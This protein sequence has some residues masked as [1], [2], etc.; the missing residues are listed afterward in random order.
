MVT[1][2]ARNEGEW[3]GL[4]ITI[5][6]AK[7]TAPPV[8]VLSSSLARLDEMWAVFV[9]PSGEA[10]VWRVPVQR[11]RRH[12]HFTRGVKALPRV[13]ITRRKVMLAGTLF[14]TIDVETVESCRIP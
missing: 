10:E 6:C 12:G 8:S 1:N 5:K 3:R 2:Q 7:S 13:E 4:D 11:L 9:L 14:G